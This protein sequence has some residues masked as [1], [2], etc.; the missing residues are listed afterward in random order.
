MLC[1]LEA[2]E[3]LAVLSWGDASPSLLELEQ[4]VGSGVAFAGVGLSGLVALL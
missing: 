1:V 4:A 3:P 2:G